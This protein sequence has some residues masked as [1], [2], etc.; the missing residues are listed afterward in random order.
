[1]VAEVAVGFCFLC[2]VLQIAAL[3]QLTGKR[4]ETGCRYLAVAM[5]AVLFVLDWLCGATGW[6]ALEALAAILIV[7]LAVAHLAILLVQES[8]QW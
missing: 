5:L 6:A 4:R 3:G 2:V 8:R 7:P 1:M